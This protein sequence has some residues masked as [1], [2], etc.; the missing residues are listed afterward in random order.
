MGYNLCWA[1]PTVP[2]TERETGVSGK[3]RETWVGERKIGVGESHRDKA[4]DRK[5]ARVAERER[6]EWEKERETG[7]GEIERETVWDGKERET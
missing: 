5:R 3:N 4:K 6:P 1:S 2:E 7:V